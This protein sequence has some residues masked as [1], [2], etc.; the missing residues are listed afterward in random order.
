M[1]LVSAGGNDL[2]FSEI[3]FKCLA[4]SPQGPVLSGSATCSQDFVKG[5][6]DQLAA[7]LTLVVKPS[8][9]VMSREVVVDSANGW[10]S[11]GGVVLVM[12]VEVG[13]AGECF[14]SFGL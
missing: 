1:V 7:R 13:P 6:N 14:S 4:L 10:G 8:L 5:G 12:I 9:G 11:D 2:G 3:L